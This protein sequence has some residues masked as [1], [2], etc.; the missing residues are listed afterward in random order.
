MRG[1][2]APR[3]D[4]L[5][6]PDGVVSRQSTAMIY[7]EIPIVQA[8]LDYMREHLGEQFNIS[9]VADHVEASKR[10]LEMRFRD[11]LRSSPHEFLTRLRV[12]RAESIL[13]APQKRSI[14]EIS[15]ECGFGT[16]TT[17]YA[18]FRRLTGKSPSIFRRESGR[19]VEIEP[20][21][22]ALRAKPKAFV[23]RIR[24]SGPLAR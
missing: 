14:E 7:S 1:K 3:E 12:Q 5:V 13:K 20:Q 23:A 9:A 17:F 2:A 24:R 18:A 8:A 10:T 15:S 11:A 19:A 22:K 6:D 21:P 16:A 4:L